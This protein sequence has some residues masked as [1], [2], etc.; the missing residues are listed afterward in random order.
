MCCYESHDGTALPALGIM[1][2]PVTIKISRLLSQD[3]EL[4]I[5]F[6][7]ICRSQHRSRDVPVECTLL[8]RQIVAHRYRIVTRRYQLEIT[9]TCW[10]PEP[11]HRAKCVTFWAIS[12]VAIGLHNS[13]KAFLFRNQRACLVYVVIS[14]LYSNQNSTQTTTYFSHESI[15]HTLYDPF[16]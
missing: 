12:G 1:V 14:R 6:R 9:D 13:S 8:R 3:N 10:E 2:S 7:V 15:K 5:T 16:Q 11:F 4:K